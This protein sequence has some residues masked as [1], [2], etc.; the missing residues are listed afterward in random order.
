MRRSRS[1]PLVSVFG[2]ARCVRVIRVGHSTMET[3]AWVWIACQ[4]QSLD[5]T[6]PG[7]FR[8]KS[9]YGPASELR[10]SYPVLSRVWFKVGPEITDVWPFRLLLLTLAFC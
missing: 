8:A 4:V 5:R 9:W 2:G 1:P 3:L 10:Q 6:Y 7:S